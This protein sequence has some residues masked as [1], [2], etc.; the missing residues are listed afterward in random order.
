MET[1][2]ALE[3]LS[4][5]GPESHLRRLSVLA[6]EALFDD[7]VDSII[8]VK[9]LARRVH[10]AMASWVETQTSAVQL[11]HYAE[12]ITNRWSGDETEL[13]E[14]LPPEL[15]E[16]IEKIVVRPYSP[17]RKLVLS[18]L[19]REPLRQLIRQL[20]LETILD[21]GRRASA[22]V[23]G[24][25]RGLGSFAKMTGDAVKNRGGALGGILGA[26]SGEVERQLER[27]AVEFADEALADI[28]EKLADAIAD[29][30]KAHQSAQ[31]RL[32]LLEGVREITLRQVSREA[33]NADLPG[34]LK[35][36]R[37][38]LAEWLA[39]P[40]S[41]DELERLGNLLLGQLLARPVRDVLA[42]A[43]LLGATREAILELLDA[44][45]SRLV[46]TTAFV[47]WLD[48]LLAPT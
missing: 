40:E 43:G 27:R 46:G 48:E 38:G 26:V 47:K 20:L 3:R 24:I 17:D 13:V 41:L 23:A 16:T 5:T 35:L 29:P 4:N 21:F 32:A 8:D 45:L 9:R 31:L 34:A 22:P 7:T 10:S 19:N 6:V 14:A 28:I 36:V 33:I 37:E 12:F 39:A 18:L 11:L 44:Q 30:A 2:V 15:T 1:R 25:A 42:E